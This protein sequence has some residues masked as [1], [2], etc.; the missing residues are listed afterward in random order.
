MRQVEVHDGLTQTLSQCADLVEAGRGGHHGKFLPANA[1]HELTGSAHMAL[2][3]VSHPLQ[4]GIPGGMTEL[5]VV[6]FE[7]INIDHQHRDAPTMALSPRPLLCE[8][9]IKV[10]SVEQTGQ[11]IGA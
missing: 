9:L 11:R 10:P 1:S 6:A 3:G 8:G 5:I 7:V 4:T 2:Q